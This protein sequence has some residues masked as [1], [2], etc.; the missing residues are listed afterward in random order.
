MFKHFMFNIFN[1][2]WNFPSDEDPDLITDLLQV[3]VPGD[4]GWRR[5]LDMAVMVP[6]L[7]LLHGSVLRPIGPLWGTLATEGLSAYYFYWFDGCPNRN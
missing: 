7:P 6:W 1:M 3:P 5:G 4:M 2:T